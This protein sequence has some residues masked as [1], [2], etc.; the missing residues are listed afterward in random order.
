MEI[1]SEFIYGVP[2]HVIFSFLRLI[3]GSYS[4]PGKSFIA[5]A[6]EAH[7]TAETYI[8]RK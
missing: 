2:D 3:D 1:L 8:Q 4:A 6:L 5:V 7:Q